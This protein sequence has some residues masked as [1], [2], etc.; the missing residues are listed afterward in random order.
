MQS[1]RKFQISALLEMRVK[2]TPSG[3]SYGPGPSLHGARRP[4]SGDAG[5]AGNMKVQSTF[6]GLQSRESEAP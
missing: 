6:E 4:Y 5:L 1:K 2:S 3:A